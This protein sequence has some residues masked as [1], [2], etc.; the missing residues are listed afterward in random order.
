VDLYY[1]RFIGQPHKKKQSTRQT[2]Q[3]TKC[4]LPKNK[5]KTRKQNKNYKNQQSSDSGIFMPSARKCPTPTH[6]SIPTCQAKKARKAKSE[7]SKAA[8]L[9]P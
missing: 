2:K 5:R 1:L 4:H 3:N 7:I 8:I 6:I 9:G